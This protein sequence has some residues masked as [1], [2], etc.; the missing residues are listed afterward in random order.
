MRLKHNLSS[1]LPRRGMSFS[2]RRPRQDLIEFL[3]QGMLFLEQA[4][5]SDGGHL[6]FVALH[7]TDSHAIMAARGPHRAA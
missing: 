6:R 7:T 4:A 2:P 5:Q 1:F 3:D